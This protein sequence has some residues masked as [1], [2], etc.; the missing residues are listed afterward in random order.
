MSYSELK[1]FKIPNLGIFVKIICI[2]I[3]FEGIY[4]MSEG[5]MKRPSVNAI[6]LLIDKYLI[7]P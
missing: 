3:D 2:G 5:E 1:K 7:N 6:T 4:L